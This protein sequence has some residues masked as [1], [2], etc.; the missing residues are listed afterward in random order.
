MN[1]ELFI[2]FHEESPN[3]IFYPLRHFRFFYELKR[4]YLFQIFSKMI[5]T[6]KPKFNPLVYTY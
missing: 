2:Y 3:I 1:D 6:S 5:E 4:T